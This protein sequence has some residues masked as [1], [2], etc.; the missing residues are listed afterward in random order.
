MLCRFSTSKGCA[1]L[2]VVVPLYPFYQDDKHV[3]VGHHD[4][5]YRVIEHNY[6]TCVSEN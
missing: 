2:Y 4:G 5:S 3:E 1:V 6:Y